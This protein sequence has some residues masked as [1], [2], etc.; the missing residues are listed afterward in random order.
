MNPKEHQLF[1]TLTATSVD[2]YLI[3]NGWIRDY[4]FKNPN[5]MV[6]SLPSQGKRI[7]IPQNETFEDFYINLEQTL[8]TISAIE[9]K[10][11]VQLIKEMATVF[12]DRMEFRIVS[13]LSKNGK[14][15]LDYAANCIEGLR[16]LVLYSAC[17]EHKKQPV[18]FK[19]SD[20]A[21][22]NLEHF[23]LAQTELG[24][25]V[26]NVDSKVVDDNYEQTVIDSNIT[27][28]IEHKIVERIYEAMNQVDSIVNQQKTLTEVTTD[29]YQ[30]G[31]TANMC[32]ALLKM[33]PDLGEAEIHTTIR[34]SSALTN[35][36]QNS[37]HIIVKS[38]HFWAINEIS[39]IYRNKA[40]I[41]DV[42]LVGIV[43]TLSKKEHSGIVERTIRLV[44]K[45][46]KGLHTVSIDLSEDDY[47]I[48]C[49]AH[50]DEQEIE[51]QGVLDMSHKIWVLTNVSSF[52]P[53]E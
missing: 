43:K 46:D 24:S 45:F 31:I 38:N 3:L 42:V 19:A 17:A 30:A 18:C 26:I 7:A 11:I 5:L 44:A 53:L 2:R 9:K 1:Y 39:K 50:R 40:A 13:D 28:P 36:T 34:Y 4:N 15:P 47:I 25:F 49:N 23:N 20:S 35:T 32:D 12:F 41:Q 6:F 29:G 16:E 37:K 51:V 33:K 48:A 8:Q 14:L 21:K 22:N 52:K 10:S 27:K